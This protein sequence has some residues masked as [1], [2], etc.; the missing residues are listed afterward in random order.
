MVIEK[1]FIGMILFELLS[2]RLSVCF[3]SRRQS[4]GNSPPDSKIIPNIPFA[5]IYIVDLLC[6]D[7]MEIYLV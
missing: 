7:E 4:Y 5:I 1:V 3:N 2:G 6:V